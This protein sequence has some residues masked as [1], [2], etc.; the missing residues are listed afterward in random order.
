ME[1]APP[2]SGPDGSFRLETKAGP[3]VL[4]VLVRPRPFTKKGLLLE[5]GKTLD[6]GTIRVETGTQIPP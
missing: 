4:V 1:G 3:S 6:V 5:A 2:T